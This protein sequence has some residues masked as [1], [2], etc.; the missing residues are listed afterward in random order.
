MKKNNIIGNCCPEHSLPKPS[1]MYKCLYCGERF[2]PILIFWPKRC[3]KCDGKNVKVTAGISKKNP[4][5]FIV[6]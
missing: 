1:L 2:K 6:N 5:P 3:P 4:I